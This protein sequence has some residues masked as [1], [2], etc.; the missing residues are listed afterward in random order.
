MS[1]SHER[2]SIKQK[3]QGQRILRSF[4]MM[5]LV[6]TAGWYVIHM[7][8][9]RPFSESEEQQLERERTREIGAKLPDLNSIDGQTALVPTKRDELRSEISR[10]EDSVNTEREKSFSAAI[11]LVDEGK[12]QEAEA[13][14]L[15]LIAKDPNDEGALTELAMIYFIDKR[16]PHSAV[17]IMETVIKLNLNNKSMVAEFVAAYQEMGKPEVALQKLQAISQS[18]QVSPALE[19]GMARLLSDQGR[20]SE[21]NEHLTRGIAQSQGEPVGFLMEQLADNYSK[22]GDA[23]KALASY[24]RVMA[25]EKQSMAGFSDDVYFRERSYE[26]KIKMLRSLYDLNRIEEVAALVQELENDHPHDKRL[27]GYRE[28]LLRRQNQMPY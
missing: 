11:R 1:R 17:S 23:E 16:D 3:S 4:A 26:L 8:A 20:W 10:D 18:Q 19:E 24:E 9:S 5:T 15:A 6:V 7:Q 25:E 2:Q 22:M 12:W 27:A 21:A 28:E 14:L 13:L